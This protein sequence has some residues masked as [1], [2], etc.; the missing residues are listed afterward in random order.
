MI[1]SG[2]PRR[3]FAATWIV[4]GLVAVC[5]LAPPAGAAPKLGQL[6]VTSVIPAGDGTMSAAA[7][8]AMNRG[9]LVL[10][11]AAYEQAKA[12]ANGTSDA[13]PQSSGAEL[14]LGMFAPVQIRG[15]AGIFDPNS[16]PSDSTSSVGSTRYLEL[17]NRRFAIFNKTTNVPISTGT[18]NTLANAGAATN[19]FDPQIMWD[20][21]TNRFYYAMDS[22]ASASTQGLSIGFSKTASPNNGSADW[23]HYFVNFGS[24]LPDYPKLGDTGNF[25]LIGSNVFNSAGSF[26]G[27]DVFGLSKPPAGTTCPAPSTFKTGEVFNLRDPVG[28]PAFTPV[29]V[30]QIDASGVGYVI[31]RTGSLPSTRFSLHRVTASATGTPVI[32]NPGLSV[33]VPSYTVPPDAPQRIGF[34][35]AAKLLD[36]LDARPTQAMSSVDPG[37]ANAVGLWVQH[38]TA[39][40]PAARSEVRWYEINPVTRTLFQSGKATSTA[41]YSFNG[42]ISSDRK[43]FGSTGQFGN[44]MVLGFS[45]SGGSTTFPAIRM[46]SKVGTAPQSGHVAVRG[47]AGNY[48]GFDC[49]GADNSCRWGDYAGA[50]P[51]PLPPTGAT[52]GRIWSVNMQPSG[53]NSTTTANWRTWNWVATP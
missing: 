49:A 32:Q 3:G 24:F 45:T 51:D 39:T 30:N 7:Q 21:Q 11:Q 38:T 15:W 8:A 12:E 23:C 13:A 5:A 6:K 22:I 36:T 26:V 53:V 2:K 34:P 20:A 46:L 27:S 25:W 19:S 14:A 4:A 9:Y 31:A 18:L 28:G 44:S 48:S 47:S 16:A 50:S 37:R 1:G 17:I 43:R 40:S 42:A 10:D 35:N 33:L 41:Y 52:I 29:V